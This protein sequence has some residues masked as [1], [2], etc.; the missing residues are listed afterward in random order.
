MVI[1]YSYVKLPEGNNDKKKKLGICVDQIMLD[2]IFP[3]LDG[4]E[5]PRLIN[6]TYLVK[7]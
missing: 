4:S 6:W 7:L 2:L 3:P 1:I 5:K